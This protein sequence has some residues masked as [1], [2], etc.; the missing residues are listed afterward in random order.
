[1]VPGVAYE[2]VERGIIMISMMFYMD[3]RDY[4][5]VYRL[6]TDP[7]VNGN[8]M[9][10]PEHNDFH[11]FKKWFLDALSS[12][13]NDFFVFYDDNEFIGVSYTYDFRLLDGHCCLTTAIRDRFQGLGLGVRCTL[14][15]LR[16]LFDTYPIRKVYLYVYKNNNGSLRSINDAGFVEEAVLREYHFT[17]G[18]YEDAVIYSIDRDGIRNILLKDQSLRHGSE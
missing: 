5:N 4:G 10:R 9:S 13:F 7:T 17:G 15:H 14:M 16:H 12:K 2:T 3:E 18:H 6:F 8:I 1:M 11:S